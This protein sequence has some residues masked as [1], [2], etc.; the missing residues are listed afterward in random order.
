MKFDPSRFAPEREAER[1]K[2]HPTAFIPFGFGPR[3]WFVPLLLCDWSGIRL[4]LVVEDTNDI[5]SVGYRFAMLEMVLVLARI[6]P[7]YNVRYIGW[8]GGA[9]WAQSSTTLIVSSLSS[10]LD[11]IISV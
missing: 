10:A 1:M 2:K 11:R 3:I 6:M 8:R 9:L 7:V 4:V 5:C